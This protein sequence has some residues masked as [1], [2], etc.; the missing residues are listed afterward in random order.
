[1]I[2]VRADL[3]AK[4][5]LCHKA[6]VRVHTRGKQRLAFRKLIEVLRLRRELQLPSAS[7]I[8]IDR[9]LP[10]E[11][12]DHVD[13]RVERKIESVGQFRADPLRE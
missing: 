12:L 2:T 10:D 8:T 9:L 4:L 11:P 1:M 5:R 7:E 13:T 3:V 6:R